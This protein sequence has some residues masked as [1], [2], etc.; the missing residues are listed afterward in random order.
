MEEADEE[1][2]DEPEDRDGQGGGIKVGI[3]ARGE[4]GG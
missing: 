4:R 3:V 2:T 1:A